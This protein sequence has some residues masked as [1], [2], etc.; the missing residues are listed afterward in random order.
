MTDARF[1]LNDASVSS[2]GS[3]TRDSG[4]T[5]T[6]TNNT[7]GTLTG[8]T[9]SP[10]PHEGKYCY[11]LTNGTGSNAI[12]YGTSGTLGIFI[13]AFLYLPT[14]T[15]DTV[16]VAVGSD[17]TDGEGLY[18]WIS[19]NSNNSVGI[20]GYYTG[21][22]GIFVDGGTSSTG[23]FPRDQWFRFQTYINGN[24]SPDYI[25]VWKGKNLYGPTADSTFTQNGSVSATPFLWY[26]ACDTVDGGSGS[27]Y[28]DD[29]IISNGT[30]LSRNVPSGPAINRIAPNK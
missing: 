8:T 22:G 5:Y 21:Y 3:F 6:F 7:G 14:G 10:K 25:S 11:G 17:P 20:Y 4:T 28:I 23:F 2:G 13:D 26:I 9:T 27:F 29:V 15:G 19:F 12:F 16:P 18:T 30:G 24:S 1:R